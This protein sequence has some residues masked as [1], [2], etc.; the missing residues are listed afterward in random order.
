MSEPWFYPLPNRSADQG[1][2]RYAGFC[3]DLLAAVSSILNV[4]Y[5][6]VPFDGKISG[7]FGNK[8]ILNIFGNY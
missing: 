4:D 7:H 6:I 5:D 1:S 2:T 3:Y 8:V